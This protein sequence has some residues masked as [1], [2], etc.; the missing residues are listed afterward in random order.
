MPVGDGDFKCKICLDWLF[1]N[2]SFKNNNTRNI[3][4]FVLTGI[5]ETFESIKLLK[6]NITYINS[7]TCLCYNRQVLYHTLLV[8]HTFKILKYHSLILF[9]HYTI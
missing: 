3:Y 8:F 6:D 9:M 1:P 7:T 4:I 5:T 2:N